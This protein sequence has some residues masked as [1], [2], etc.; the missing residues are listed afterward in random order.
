MVLK[1]FYCL[2]ST[3]TLLS[4]LKFFERAKALT[5]CVY[6]TQAV[7]KIFDCKKIIMCCVVVD[8]ESCRTAVV[9]G[10]VH[11]GCTKNAKPS[12]AI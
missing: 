2:E 5:H 11:Q 7:G 3:L 1:I 8:F 4:K 10:L 9:I 12:V 6:S